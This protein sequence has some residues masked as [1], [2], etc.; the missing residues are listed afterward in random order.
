MNHAIPELFNLAN[1]LAARGDK[2]GREACSVAITEI[3]R[4]QGMVGELLPH[5]WGEASQRYSW[6]TLKKYEEMRAAA[7]VAKEGS[8][9]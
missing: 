4:L 7:I 9:E 1:G 5:D 6:M 2:I 8:D 3:E